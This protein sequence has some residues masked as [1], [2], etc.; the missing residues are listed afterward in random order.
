MTIE[1]KYL[2]WVT[3][4]TAILWMPYILNM[5][6]VR[7]L[8]D[9]VGYPDNPKPLSSWAARMKN[10]HANAIENLA[11]FA[12]LV[13]IAHVVGLSTDATVLASVVYFWA[14]VVHVVSLTF[15][16][17]WVRTLAFLAGFGC[18][19]TFAWQILA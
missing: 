6:F 13:L 5:I 4:L 16:I 19:L 1:L 11:V 8:I 15:R 10:A 7:G 18:Q 14:R 12:V 9:A 17:S 2:T 3:V